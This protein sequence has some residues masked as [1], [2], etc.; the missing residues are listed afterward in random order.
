MSDEEQSLLMSKT[1]LNQRP[2]ETDS[3]WALRFQKELSKKIKGA[4]ETETSI[5]RVLLLI[6]PRF[7]EKLYS[8]VF[9]CHRVE[10]RDIIYR[11]LKKNGYLQMFGAC[12]ISNSS[13]LYPDIEILGD[14]RQARRETK[15]QEAKM[16]GG[17]AIRF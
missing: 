3:E 11:E 7:L 17:K 15:L 10:A 2:K 8:V 13:I 14:I 12:V 9:A 1:D 4:V 5:N 16:F 6:P